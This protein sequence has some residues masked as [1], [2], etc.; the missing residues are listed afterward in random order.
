MSITVISAPESKSANT[1]VA[2]Y[3]MQAGNEFEGIFFPFSKN[4]TETLA[5]LGEELPFD[6]VISEL[7][8]SKLLDEPFE[9]WKDNV[10]P[11][12]RAVSEIKKMNFE[13]QVYCYR[14]PSSIKLLVEILNDIARL[15]LRQAITK[16]L[17][18]KDLEEW[19]KLL[20]KEKDYQD[21]TAIRDADSIIIDASKHDK[22]T[23][24]SNYNTLLILA[25]L[26]EE[27]YGTQRIDITS[28]ILKQ[29][30]PLD[31][32]RSEFRTGKIPEKRM[33]K[34]IQEH[35]E[36]VKQCVLPSTTLDEAHQKWT[37][38]KSFVLKKI[39]LKIKR[40]SQKP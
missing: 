30:L 10:E 13:V 26:R 12:L 2:D 6:W 8:D 38:Q 1:Q 23:C 22:S 21:A 31:I 33:R 14:L 19:T 20:Q 9:P 28:P 4:L 25:R 16:E 18:E 40:L 34:L 36:F 24:I 7:R 3:L 39:L 35:G 37:W 32:L 17:N 15:T 27:G 29:P 5:K 11:L